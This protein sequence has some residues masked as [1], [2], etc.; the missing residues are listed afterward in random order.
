MKPARHAACASSHRSAA[1]SAGFS[2]S[3]NDL[4]VRRRFKHNR[5]PSISTGWTHEARF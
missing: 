3:A 1:N 4:T 2:S 5:H